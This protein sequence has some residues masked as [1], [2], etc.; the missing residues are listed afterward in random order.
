[1]NYLV[2]FVLVLVLN[3]CNIENPP[4]MI[5]WDPDASNNPYNPLLAMWAMVTRTTG[6]SCEPD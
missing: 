6:L 3:A 4:D 1:M 2:Q 5:K